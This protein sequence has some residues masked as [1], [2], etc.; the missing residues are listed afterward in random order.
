VGARTENAKRLK[1]ACDE[2]QFQVAESRAG[3][4]VI[5]NKLTELDADTKK[6][7]S[8][9]STWREALAAW[10]AVLTLCA[11]AGE[12]HQKQLVRLEQRVS[13][14]IA[15]LKRESAKSKT[16]TQAISGFM[17]ALQRVSNEILTA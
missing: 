10:L 8:S 11:N 4:A 15:T 17:Q 13:D 5:E 14:E 7:V 16:G 3:L 6:T 12:K 9:I 2:F 1:S